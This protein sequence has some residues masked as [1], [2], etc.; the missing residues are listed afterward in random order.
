[1]NTF[2][3]LIKNEVVT[4]DC[5]KLK[6]FNLKA[7]CNIIDVGANIGMF[8]EYALQLYPQCN[9]FAFELVKDN[10]LAA[11][12]RLSPFNNVNIFNK[13][14]VGDSTPA[15]MFLHKSNRGGH[16]VIFEDSKD[17]C[18]KES[19]NQPFEKREINYIRFNE[20]L[21]QVNGQVDLLKLDCEGGEYDILLQCSKLGLFKR[22][23]TIVME[24][25]G[26]HSKEYPIIKKILSDNY[27]FFNSVNHFIYCSKTHDI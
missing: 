21:K 15:G 24:I 16:K 27:K 14:V 17:Y 6:K 3:N 22:I 25:H 2:H 12:A 4:Q 23:D 20:V 5:Y 10:Y 26:R 9:I 1:M 18:N 19:F 11:R 7:D 13:A 8:S